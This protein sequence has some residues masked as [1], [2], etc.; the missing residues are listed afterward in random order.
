MRRGRAAPLAG[1]IAAA[2]A[3]QTPAARAEVDEA[4]IVIASDLG[5]IV[6]TLAT[7]PGEPA[8]AVLLL[9]GFTGSRD[10][11]RIPATGQGI[12]ERAAERLG[13]AGYASLRIDFRG[14]GES[15]GT[16]DFAQTT[17]E[18]QTA[19]ALAA[20]DWLAA[21]PRVAG[22]RPFVLGWSQ[23]GLVAALTV[24]ARPDD[25]AAV[26]LWNAVADPE[27]TYGG[28]L[29]RRTIARGARAG[30]DEITATMP[31][32]RQITL[33]G[34]FFE[35]VL[36]TDPPGALTGYPGPVLVARGLADGVVDPSQ[37]ALFL[38]AHEGPEISWLWDM[39]H[40]FD[41]G[42]GTADLDALLAAT[43]ALFDAAAP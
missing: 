8:P 2:L 34:P 5:E 43:I 21:D 25:I 10:E 19:D 20:L 41:V 6:G 4:R 13:A 14:S 42:E 18:G 9:H 3:A 1:V 17:F 16:I 32:G 26:A 31:G 28:L 40:G 23:G 29:G 27:A 37:G 24:G 33:A 12:F 7:P 15:L 30:D 35:G 11:A 36:S 22:A 38:D 39:N